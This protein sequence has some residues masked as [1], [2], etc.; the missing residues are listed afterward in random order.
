LKKIRAVFFDAGNTLLYLDYPFLVEQLA[1]EN[2]ETDVDTVKE[3]EYASRRAVDARMAEGRL[4]DA[5]IWPAYISGILEGCGLEGR[6]RVAAVMGRLRERNEFLSLWTYVPDEVRT[7]LVELRE[8]GYKLG[9]ISNSDGSLANLLE[10]TGLESAVDFALDSFV[11][12]WEKPAREIFSIALEKAGEPPEA[13]VHVGDIVAADVMGARA[14]GIHPV[15]L[16]PGKTQAD[17]GCDVIKNIVEIT[18][19][20]ERLQEKD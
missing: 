6:E 1:A 4:K 20:V 7:T 13:C 15:L 18:G 9:I 11:V 5:D 8:D 14:S 10:R 16:D 2:H 17:A 19:V 12:G 3:A